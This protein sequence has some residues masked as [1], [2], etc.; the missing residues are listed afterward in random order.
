M[1]I[2]IPEDNKLTVECRIEAGCL[3]PA[4]DEHVVDFCDF[5]KREFS[6]WETEVI[7]WRFMP[8]PDESLAELQYKFAGKNLS[9]EQARKYLL[10][11]EKDIDELEAEIDE[12]LLVL[13]DEYMSQ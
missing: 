4:G 11:L 10:R 5:A 1:N 8:R 3:G 6:S 12:T 2:E 9:R 7:N 13:I